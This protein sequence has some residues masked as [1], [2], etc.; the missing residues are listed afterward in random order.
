M[1]N[2]DRNARRV[3]FIAKEVLETREQAKLAQN[4]ITAGIA[5]TERDKLALQYNKLHKELP[6]SEED[7]KLEEAAI[8][9]ILAEREAHEAAF[10]PF[11]AKKG[12]ARRTKKQS[13]N[14][15]QSRKQSRKQAKK[16]SKKQSRK[17]SK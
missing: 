5:L 10:N 2:I 12:G 6:I 14:R 16:Q 1:A 4:K 13:R 9:R 7:R 11:G 3:E 8:A 17:Q 15:K